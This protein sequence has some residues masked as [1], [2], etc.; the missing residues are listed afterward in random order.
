MPAPLPGQDLLLSAKVITTSS[1][2]A[3]ISFPYFTVMLPPFLG[4]ASFALH[5]VFKIQPWGSIIFYHRLIIFHLSGYPI[6]YTSFLLLGHIQVVTSLRLLQINNAAM[7]IIIYLLIH[8]C[9]YFFGCIY[10]RLKLVIG[11]CISLFWL[12]NAKISG[13]ANLLFLQYLILV[14]P[15]SHQYPVIQHLKNFSYSDVWGEKNLHSLLSNEIKLL[16]HIFVHFSFLL[17]E[18]PA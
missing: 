10:L 12:S 5:Y 2:L 18:M 3:I 7:M 11:L 16:F 1:S 14:T 17:C 15:Y 9:I 8:R 13:C 4:Q 6:I